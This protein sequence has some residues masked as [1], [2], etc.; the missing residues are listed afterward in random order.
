MYE[1]YYEIIERD[2]VENELRT[3]ALSLLTITLSIPLCHTWLAF[4]PL[5]LLTWLGLTRS[6]VGT[7]MV[8]PRALSSPPLDLVLP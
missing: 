5:D 2:K 6:H 3:W 1:I 8:L 7:L 4:W